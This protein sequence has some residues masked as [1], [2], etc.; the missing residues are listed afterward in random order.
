MNNK[1]SYYKV[2]NELD[3]LL[4]NAMKNID[5]IFSIIEKDE[6]FKNYFLTQVNELYWFFPLKAKGYFS[7]EKAPWPKETEEKGTYTFPDWNVLPYLEKVSEQIN[8]IKDEKEKDSYIIALLKIIEDVTNYHRIN[9]KKLDNFKIWTYFI[10]ILTNLPTNKIPMKI[11]DLIPE[12]IESK[13]TNL[14]LSEEI[15]MRLL[16][17]FLK[18]D[19]PEDI[20]KAE[21]IMEYITD[22]KAVPVSDE[23]SKLLGI[24]EEPQLKI[25]LYYLVEFF[26][27]YGN[28]IGEKC[29]IA[30]IFKI[31]ENLKKVFKIR[32]PR[33]ILNIESQQHNYQL[34]VIHL[35][36]FTFQCIIGEVK[37]K[38]KTD[39]DKKEIFYKPLPRIKKI[40]QFK[41]E[42]CHT[43]NQFIEIVRK[44]ISLKNKLI[45]KNI[46]KKQFDVLYE[47]LYSDYSFITIKSLFEPGEFPYFRP[48]GILILIL[49]DIVLAKVKEDKEAFERIFKE[50]TG[51]KY[52]YPVFK[53]ILLY[54][55][56]NE[57]EA[58]KEKFWELI[59]KE[60]DL[61]F[62][63]SYYEAEIYTIL[64]KYVKKFSQEE[65]N[66]LKHIIEKG[67]QRYVPE[68]N[69]EKYIASWKQKWY[70]ALKE[71]EEFKLLYEKY[72]EI[73]KIEE[74]PSFKPLEVRVG[75][76]E[77]PLSK[78][79]IIKSGNK[80]LSEFLNK[81]RTKDP[82][83]GPTV[84]GLA[85]T[86]KVVTNEMPEK[87]IDDFE[88]FLHLNYYYMYY[89]LWGIKDAIQERKNIGWNNLLTF[90]NKYVSQK[91]FWDNKLILRDIWGDTLADYLWVIGMIG[92][93]IQEG[94]KDKEW[95][96]PEDYFNETKKMLIFIL[97]K[98]L[99][100]RVKSE[101]ITDISMYILNS[102]YGK[103]I[104]AL[105]YLS[106]RIFEKKKEW[107]SD[108]KNIYETLLENEILEAYVIIG[109]Y[110]PEFFNYLD[111]KW[112]EEKIKAFTSEKLKFDLWEG[113]MEDYLFINKV[114][115]ELYKLMRKHYLKAIN[116]NFKEK[117]I[118]DRLAQHICVAYLQGFEDL[119]D[120]NGLFYKLLK[121]WNPSHIREVIGFMWMQMELVLSEINEEKAPE[122]K[123][124]MDNMRDRIIDFWRWVYEN[125]FKNKKE[126]TQDDKEILSDFVRLTI[127]LRE[128]NEENK[129]WLLKSAPYAYLNF[130]AP[131]FIEYLNNLKDKDVSGGKY[132]GEIFLKILE[133]ST[134]DY[135]MEHII[136]IVDFI[137]KKRYKELGNRICNIYGSR[138]SL[139]LRE[140][141]DKYNK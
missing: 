111:K 28:K 31:A 38:R 106:I 3:S 46:N 92:E 12:W 62:D 27:K 15:A 97:N 98:M 101:N 95:H 51:D 61:L 131:F 14:S 125:K 16:P 119:P 114:D 30:L 113:F 53:R 116:Y 42:N 41:I 86:L 70:S 33:S 127:Y 54:I 20:K 93:I 6:I 60:S 26:K 102:S 123:K 132:L 136:E 56:G 129:E 137:Y 122:I 133:T 85:E 43:K 11:I 71:D 52:Q 19:E 69:Q 135:K 58:F 66:K 99:E 115:I 100:K 117:I 50:F 29:S 37:S 84:D 91:E 126:V 21:K 68:K 13:F 89:I 35:K 103:I 90:L 105:L 23:R 18:S 124:K 45:E 80:E 57:W 138:G 134:P 59:N 76:G 25:D 1:R 110:M 10:K 104:T 9:N 121:N 74:E 140:T 2:L 79:D 40:M 78:E 139:F 36:D 94:T 24:K 5:K 4:I 22:I 34:R 39:K 44:E 17:K 128:I 47:D 83:K 64:K 81:F 120:K 32:H 48:D 8:T 141:Y 67:P 63:S 72:R 107:D 118:E 87:F 49:R 112:L 7:P 96:I 65:K 108:I 77:T 109:H 73:T 130:N 82:I 55:I 88:P 75:P